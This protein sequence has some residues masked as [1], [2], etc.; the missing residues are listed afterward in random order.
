MSQDNPNSGWLD[1]RL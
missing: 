1:L